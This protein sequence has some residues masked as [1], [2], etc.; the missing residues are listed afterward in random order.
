M[1]P[2]ERSRRRSRGSTRGVALEGN[3]E[4]HI[5]HDRDGRPTMAP[6]HAEQLRARPVLD[7]GGVDHGE[8]AAAQ[9][10]GQDAVEQVEGVVGGALGAGDRRRSSRAWRPRRGSRS[11]RNG[12][13]RRCSCRWPQPRPGG[14]AHRRGS[15]A[16]RKRTG[17]RGHRRPVRWSWSADL[18]S[19][20]SSALG[21][22]VRAHLRVGDRGLRLTG[23]TRKGASADGQAGL[24][25][26]MDLAEMAIWQPPRHITTL[27]RGGRRHRARLRVRA[28]IVPE[29]DPVHK[30]APNLAAWPAQQ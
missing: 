13:V 26:E 25:N 27:A 12:V 11:R 16:R 30:S 8:P 5:Q 10:H 19:A 4:R 23:R 1:L 3:L 14:P 22:A 9:A 17:R 20:S 7:I 21:V 2:P 6:R 24:A 18:E 28:S 29:I 15:E